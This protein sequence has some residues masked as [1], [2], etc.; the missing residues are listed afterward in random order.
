MMLE[1]LSNPSISASS[2]LMVALLLLCSLLPFL[3]DPESRL[4]ISSI[5]LMQGDYFLASLKSCRTRLA[6]TP[7]NI[8]SK[9]EPE[10]KMK[11]QPASPAMARA[12]R[13]LPVPGSPNNITPLNS[14]DPFS[15]YISGFLMTLMIFSTSS[16]ISSIP[17]TSSSRWSMFSA[18]LIS[19]FALPPNY[20][21]LPISFMMY[22][23]A[24][25]CSPTI[26]MRT[27][28]FHHFFHTN[29]EMSLA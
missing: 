29:W 15:L 8:S 6:P 3:L 18:V 12:S 11:L 27:T 4:S 5:K 13:V 20:S 16:L 1:F 9:S 28:N 26:I 7:T 24:Y 17:L 14:F 23:R 21:L 10:Q 19:N 25:N 22:C 2:W